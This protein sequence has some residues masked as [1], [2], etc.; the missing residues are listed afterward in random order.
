M[1]KLV[2][3]CRFYT[4]YNLSCS[5]IMQVL[6]V[7]QVRDITNVSP[8]NERWTKRYQWEKYA[9]VD[10][11]IMPLDPRVARK[12]KEMDEKPIEMMNNLEAAAD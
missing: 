1:K 9:N 6:T 11:T 5:H 2:C 3:N 7:N 10:K 4:I 12:I 8:C